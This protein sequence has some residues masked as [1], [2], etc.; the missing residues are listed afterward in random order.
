MPRPQFSLKTMLWGLTAVACC[1]APLPAAID[2]FVSASWHE[3]G[4][5]AILALPFVVIAAALFA[6]SGK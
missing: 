3:I 5:C 2:L 6:V 1:V 4:I